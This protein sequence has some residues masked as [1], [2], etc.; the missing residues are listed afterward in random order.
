MKIQYQERK[1]SV[2]GGFYTRAER[3]LAK[4]D[5]YFSHD[6]EAVIKIDRVR[7]A[8]SVEVTVSSQSMYFRAE[9]RS[10]NS[11]AA[12][13]DAVDA[14]E[15]QIRKHR[16][17]LG[18]R[19]R[20]TAFDKS[21]MDPQDVLPVEDPLRIVRTKH[22]ALKSMTAEEAVLQMDLLGH[23]FYAFRNAEADD[24][25]CIV[26]MRSDGNYGLIETE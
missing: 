19:I 5:R 21:Y 17:K 16:T 22:F 20:E 9:E 23:N 12:L 6:S 3:K 14:I 15:R 7:E 4:L 26:Y 1:A 11:Y 18:K 25:V 24:M 2:D 10:E 13:D 8:Y